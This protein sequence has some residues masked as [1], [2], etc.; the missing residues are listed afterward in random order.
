MKRISLILLML[1]GACAGDPLSSA[2]QRCQS[3]GLAG[4][5]AASCALNL[6]AQEQRHH[7]EQMR[8]YDRAWSIYGGQPIIQ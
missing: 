7:E 1:L 8:G 5:A 6:H 3:L 4:D 2:H